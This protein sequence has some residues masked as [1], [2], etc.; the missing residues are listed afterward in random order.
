MGSADIVSAAM[1]GAVSASYMLEQ[2]GPPRLERAE[3]DSPQDRFNE[4]S[5]RFHHRL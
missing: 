5:G 4:L 3:G 2:Y 1:R